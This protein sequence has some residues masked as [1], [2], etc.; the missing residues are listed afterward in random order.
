MTDNVCD[1]SN[2]VYILKNNFL[3]LD[4]SAFLQPVSKQMM[5]VFE[6]IISKEALY[7]KRDRN[8]L[9]VLKLSVLK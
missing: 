6:V 1:A 2:S 4:A 3:K 8:S 5:P 9:P 7:F